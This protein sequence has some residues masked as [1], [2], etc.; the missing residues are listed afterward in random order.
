MKINSTNSEFSPMFFDEDIV[1]A[2]A[3]DSSVFNTRR[4]K[5]NNQ[6]YL[7]LYV[8]K[9]N[10][11]SQELKNAIK[12]S[13]NVNTKYH[14][15]SVA[16]SPDN[17]TMYFTRNNYGKKLKRDKKGVNHL[18]IYRSKKVNGEWL[19]ATEVSFNSD[20]YSTG[21]PAISKD[22]KKMYFVSDMPGSLGETDIF[23]VDIN[24]DGTFSEPRNLGPE[25]NTEQKE[26][27]PFI[28]D[29]KFYFS[30]NGHI[31]LGG[32]DVYEA[33]FDA[34]KGFTDVKNLGKPINSNKDDF[35]YIVNEETQKG[36]FASNRD[37]GKG[38]DDI[39]S[40]KRLII[41]EIPENK[42]AIAGTVTDLVTGDLMPKAMV[43]LLDENN[44]KLKEVVTDEDGSFIFEDL[45]SNTRYTLKT[46]SSEAYFEDERE[47]VTEDNTTVNV[48]VELR[49]LKEMIAVEDGI[50]KLKTE[51]IHFNFDK[52]FIRPDAASELDK[53]VEVMTEYPD[54]VIKI[55][56][57]TDSRGS[58]VY[59]KYLSG[60]RATSTKDY[61]ISKG[62][63]PERIQSAIGYGEEKLLNECDGS[64]A[65]TEQNHYLNRRSEFII[66]E[67]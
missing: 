39:Y 32:L 34:E 4:Y 52:S 17:K 14:E 53:L 9:L 48:A 51:M 13:K 11:E 38:D 58:A 49:K 59:N 63:A 2:S 37:G 16:F 12:F 54:M 43:E 25:I 27:F 31:G 28:N 21:H 29:T 8:S 45:D 20:A 65:C 3:M 18:K 36:Y 22:G 5:W 46:T 35:S 26:M 30:S 62:I 15:A 1:F 57:H 56:S 41:E 60:K 33:N 23:V 40:F 19:E 50:R 6:P 44:I 42:N 61:I 67:M 66:V 64:V 7:D 10:E 24:E 47:T 55:E